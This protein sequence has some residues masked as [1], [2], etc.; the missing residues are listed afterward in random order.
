MK[1]ALGQIAHDTP[2]PS[3]APMARKNAQNSSCAILRARLRLALTS[4]VA[5]KL[6]FINRLATE[7][8]REQDRE[9]EISGQVA[10]FKRTVEDL[11]QAATAKFLVD[12]PRKKKATQRKL[13]G[14]I[15]L[16]ESTLRYCRT[17]PQAAL[18]NLTRLQTALA[19]LNPS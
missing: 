17:N 10:I 2:Q 3:S 18:T 13:A 8:R 11:V 5:G 16:P 14:L 6:E 7:D 12:N 19:R 1:T 15:G 4:P 9:R